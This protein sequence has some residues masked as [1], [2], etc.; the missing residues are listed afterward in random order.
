MLPIYAIEKRRK[1]SYKSI[2]IVTKEE[3]VKK[4]THRHTDLNKVPV[5]LKEKAR[6]DHQVRNFLQEQA[7]EAT[8]QKNGKGKK[9]KPEE[10][11]PQRQHCPPEKRR[12]DRNVSTSIALPSA[13]V[14]GS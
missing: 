9:P 1:Y 2:L 8:K 5:L 12:G 14:Q 4:Y 13:Y 6:G 7:V 11:M 10:G 3:K